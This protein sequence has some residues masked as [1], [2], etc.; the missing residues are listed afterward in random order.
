MWQLKLEK[1]I[2]STQA[3]P[4]GVT[5]VDDSEILKTVSEGRKTI[6]F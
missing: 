4:S 1:T 5:V 6:M 2:F 3:V